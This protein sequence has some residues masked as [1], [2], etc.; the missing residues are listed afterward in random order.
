[1]YIFVQ[2]RDATTG[3]LLQKL[4]LTNVTV[5][6]DA[7]YTKPVCKIEL[8]NKDEIIQTVAV[9]NTIMVCI[10]ELQQLREGLC[11]LGVADLIEKYPHLLQPFFVHQASQKITAGKCN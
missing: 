5:L 6:I 8:A 11:A 10:R 7:G 3:E 2:I 9:Q 4:C 1:M